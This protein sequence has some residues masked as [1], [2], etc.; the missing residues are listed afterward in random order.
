MIYVLS[1]G[2]VHEIAQNEVYA[3]PGKKCF[4]F[5]N[6][7]VEVSNLEG[8]EFTPLTGA[9]TVGAYTSAAFIRAP[10]AAGANVSV[11]LD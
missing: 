11:K 1:A 10:G 2:P 4:V 7:A 6:N 5:S 9:D 8:S 3:L